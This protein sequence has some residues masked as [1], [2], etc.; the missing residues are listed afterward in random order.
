MADPA[1]ASLFPPAALDRV[2]AAIGAV[3]ARALDPF[4]IRLTDILSPEFV[5]D[6]Q[7][8]PEICLVADLDGEADYFDVFGAED[9]IAAELGLEVCIILRRAVTARHLPSLEAEMQLL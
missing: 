7:P 1:T 9:A 4:G 8:I 3:K 5:R 6:N 2:K